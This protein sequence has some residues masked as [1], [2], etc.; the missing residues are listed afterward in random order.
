MEKATP[1][2]FM[3]SVDRIQKKRLK[4]GVLSKLL[5]PQKDQSACDSYSSDGKSPRSSFLSIVCERGEMSGI[6][7]R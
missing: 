7:R 2:P 5:N 3:G 1:N 6:G 4:G